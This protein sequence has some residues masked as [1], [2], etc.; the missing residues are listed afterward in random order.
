MYDITDLQF[1]AKIGDYLKEERLKVVNQQCKMFEYK[2]SFY[3]K[4][5][6]RL[7]DIIISSIALIVLMPI[8]LILAV[9]TL[10]ILG[11]PLFYTQ[12]RVGKDGKIF[13]L[14]KFRNMTEKKDQYG[15]LLPA[16]QRVT[17]FGIFLRKTS[18]DELLNF[19][20]ILKGDMSLI[21]P[22]ALPPVYSERY[23][24]FHKLRLKVRP[25][26]ECPPRKSIQHSRTWNEQFEN[27]CWYV[28]NVSFKTDCRMVLSLI[29]YTLN[30]KEAQK[31]SRCQKGSFIG[32]EWNGRAMSSYELTEEELDL[33]IK[34]MEAK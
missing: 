5:I 11:R 3:S 30:R 15:N 20:N 13:K 33:I 6:K 2:E 26:L 27:D 31:R 7:L 14:T 8:N 34:K 17:K 21:G 10:I 29:K 1:E 16:K 28:Q 12:E 32:Y 19:W 24:D 18:L 22:R 9:L 23:S 25:G 4:Y